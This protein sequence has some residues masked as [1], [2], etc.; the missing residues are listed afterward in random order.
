MLLDFQIQPDKPG[1][2]GGQKGR[3]GR[4]RQRQLEGM[5]GVRTVMV[6]HQGT[7]GRDPSKLKEWPQKEKGKS[8]FIVF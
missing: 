3:G 2:G 6:S 4:Q 8:P 1:D 7:R 5:W